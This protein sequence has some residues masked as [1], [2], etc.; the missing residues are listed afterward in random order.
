MN[1]NVENIC[2][3]THTN[4]TNCQKI[5]QFECRNEYQNKYQTKNN[6]NDNNGNND[7]NDND[8]NDN[9]NFEFFASNLGYDLN[10]SNDDFLRN[11]YVCKVM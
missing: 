5:K 11:L 9:F 3:S 6:N 8:N 2:I 1:R 10:D 7:N 4:I